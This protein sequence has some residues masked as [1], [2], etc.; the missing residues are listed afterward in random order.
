MHTI[1]L[2]FQASV[3][4]CELLLEEITRDE[5][6]VED[7]SSRTLATLFE[8]VYIDD[9]SLS[10]PSLQEQHDAQ[11]T[12]SIRACGHDPLPEVAL[13]YLDFIIEERLAI[14]LAELFS[15][16]SVVEVAVCS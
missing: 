13:K 1:D 4:Y 12:I 11:L 7:L 8:T 5:R 6:V 9:V 14:A 16:V 10:V 2:S 3:R 15:E